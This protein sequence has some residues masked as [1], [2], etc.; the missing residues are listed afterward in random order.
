VQARQAGRQADRQARRQAGLHTCV[1]AVMIVVS[2]P[3][4]WVAT[5]VN[6]PAGLPTS[7]PFCQLRG[8]RQGAIHQGTDGVRALKRWRQVVR[9]S[10]DLEAFCRSCTAFGHPSTALRDGDSLAASRIK[11]GLAGPQPVG[12]KWAV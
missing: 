2:I 6:S 3:P 10:A 9:C 4:P 1:T 8:V 7:A 5:D 11:E 12:C